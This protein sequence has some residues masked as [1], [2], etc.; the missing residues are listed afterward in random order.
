[1]RSDR[2]DFFFFFIFARVG[3][4]TPFL[5][6]IMAHRFPEIASIISILTFFRF[7]VSYDDNE[8][9]LSWH[10][11][12][13]VTVSNSIEIP[14]YTLA[15]HNFSSDIENFTTG[16]FTSNNNLIGLTMLG[17]LAFLTPFP[18][19]LSST[20]PFASVAEIPSSFSSVFT[21][22]NGNEVE[23]ACDEVRCGSNQNYTR[24]SATNFLDF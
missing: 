11:D 16:N 20:L 10:K 1:M 17:F 2:K 24:I 13:P 8:L 9:T 12:N 14:S 21:L 4:K 15:S 18:S 22:H 7:P 6:S 19:W 23:D 3:L 5:G